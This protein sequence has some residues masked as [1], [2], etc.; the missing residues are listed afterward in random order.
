MN[1]WGAT[2]GFIFGM[3]QSAACTTVDGLSQRNQIKKLKPD[4]E[5]HYHCDTIYEYEE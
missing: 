1:R 5:K 3:L 2:A 4:K